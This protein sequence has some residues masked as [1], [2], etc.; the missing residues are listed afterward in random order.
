MSAIVAKRLLEHL[1]RLGVVVMKK[2]AVGW[3]AALTRG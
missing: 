2:P 3:A 1:E